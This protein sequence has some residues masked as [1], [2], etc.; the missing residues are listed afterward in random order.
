M[1]A[2]ELATILDPDTA[3]CDLVLSDDGESV[4]Q[5]DTQ[6]D[7][8]DI[9]ERFNPCC[10]VQ[11]YDGFT[12]RE[13]LLGGEGDGCRRM[14]HGSVSTEDVKKKDDIEFKPEQGS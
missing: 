5:G 11:G 6:Q 7:I 3:H 8:L 12:F 2:E 14:G 10:C 13:T 4:K 9:P 1:Q